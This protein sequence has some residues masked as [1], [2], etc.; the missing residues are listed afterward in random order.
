MS[1]TNFTINTINIALV[2]IFFAEVDFNV[3]V[4][5]ELPFYAAAELEH[6]LYLL[7][8]KFLLNILDPP[9][10]RR[11]AASCFILLAIHICLCA[12]KK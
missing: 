5:V 1:C 12:Q 8:L 9:I 4:V 6:L 3:E 7:T 2:V 10:F 11:R